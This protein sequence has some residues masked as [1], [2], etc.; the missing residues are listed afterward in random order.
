ME[1]LGTIDREGGRCSVR[2][3]RLY[4]ATAD[5]LWRALTDPEQLPGWLG[6]ATRW[7]LVAG[8]E[9]ELD[10]G[11]PT[12]GRIRTVE[13]GRVLELDWNY[14]DEP[15]SIVRFEIVPRRDGVLLVLEHRR[16]APESAPGYGAGWHAHLD[17][18]AM[19][20]AL[21]ADDWTELY[22]E[23]LPAYRRHAAA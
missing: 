19:P 6:H 15:E 8:A 3:E 21:T 18:L 10:L 2:F 11:G 12:T 4:D 16:L 17:A 5:E 23:R 9:Y 20:F 14:E 7:E 1:P 13:P 22:R